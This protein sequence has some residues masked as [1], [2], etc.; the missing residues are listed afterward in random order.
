MLFNKID[1]YGVAV[2]MDLKLNVV[3]KT[4]AFSPSYI[5]EISEV[6]P[7]YRDHK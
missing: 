3:N 6:K 5:C 2:K 7:V 1:G 4:K